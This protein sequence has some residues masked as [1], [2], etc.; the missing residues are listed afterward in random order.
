MTPGAAIERRFFKDRFLVPV[1]VPL[2]IWL[3]LHVLCNN[4]D[5]IR[6]PALYRGTAFL[7][8]VLVVIVVG[9]SSAL[10]VFPLMYSRGST[11]AERIAGSYLLPLLFIVK[12]VYR[13]NEFFTF[14]E[15]LYYA[16]SSMLLLLILGQAGLIGI[17]EIICRYRYR[18]RG[19]LSGPV[20]SAGPVLSLL[21]SIAAIFVI[22]IW[23]TGENWFY[24]YQEGYR[25]LFQH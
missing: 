7:A 18:R 6:D 16:F 12:E 15:S 19:L 22:L 4:I 17:S 13:V 11:L 23:N 10:F 5:I 8:H 9:F 25:I 24:F 1:S 20:L 14:G 2:A 21:L 3:A